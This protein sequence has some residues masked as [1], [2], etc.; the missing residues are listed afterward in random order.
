MHEHSMVPARRSSAGLLAVLVFSAA[1]GAFAASASRGN[2][3]GQGRPASSS[4]DPSAAEVA[5]ARDSLL[6][7]LAASS[8]E[9][10]R[11]DRILLIGFVSPDSSPAE[12]AAARDLAAGVK[13]RTLADRMLPLY[14]RMTPDGQSALLRLFDTVYPN[15]RGFNYAVA[16]VIGRS[17]GNP[18]PA[19]RAAA[20]ELVGKYRIGESY[21]TLRKR[22]NQSRGTDRIRAIE[23]I[24][25]LADGRAAWFLPAL[26]DDPEPGVREA[27]YDAL[28]GIGRP[29]T[30]ALKERLSSR[31]PQHR[32]LALKALMPQ[33]VV[34]D[35]P[36]LY[37]F[38]TANPGLDPALKEELF[39]LL[40]R[41]EVQRDQGIETG[42]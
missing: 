19:V 35:L 27:V 20:D 2:S 15:L 4:T 7:R 21:F 31:D 13:P 5:T 3:G 1:N 28:R 32:M 30:L 23:T 29:G 34:D 39:A 12:R 42:S 25:K 36:D 14:D 18:N 22:C 11:A 16:N 33:A 41:L 17:T 38:A 37:R 8:D 40:A 10:A 24:G 9:N 6:D 26:L